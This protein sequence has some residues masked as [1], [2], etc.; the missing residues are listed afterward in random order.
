W[1]SASATAIIADEK[2]YIYQSRNSGGNRISVEVF[3]NDH[4]PD[5]KKLTV[6]R[7]VDSGASY[8]D[9]TTDAVVCTDAGLPWTMITVM[10][11]GGAET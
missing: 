7:Y 6:R 10:A 8:R 4:T 1:I 2:K 3:F 5:P 11:H 9:Y